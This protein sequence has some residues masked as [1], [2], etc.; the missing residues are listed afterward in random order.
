MITLSQNALTC[1]MILTSFMELTETAAVG[2]QPEE[3]G[4]KL[5]WKKSLYVVPSCKLTKL[6]AEEHAVISKKKIHMVTVIVVWPHKVLHMRSLCNSLIVKHS[7]SKNT[8]KLGG[9]PLK[10]V[11][12]MVNFGILMDLP[13]INLKPS[14]ATQNSH[15]DLNA[16]ITIQIVNGSTIDKDAP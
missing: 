1:L 8:Q 7:G 13:I 11:T 5:T 16:M 2:F 10:M 6:F 12:K 9:L 15:Q 4:K 3:F 14:H